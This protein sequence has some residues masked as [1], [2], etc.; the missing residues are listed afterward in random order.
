MDIQ[1][2]FLDTNV[3]EGAKFTYEDNKLSKLLELCEE[4]NI[5]VY[6]DST[7]YQEVQK[8]IRTNAEESCKGL[9]NKNLPFISRVSNLPE[10]KD[11]IQKQIEETL[12]TEFLGL[13][14]EGRLNIISK[15]ISH[16]EL[17]EMYFGEKAPFNVDNKKSEFPDA[18]IGLTLKEYINS[19]G[20]HILMISND[21]G[22]EDFCKSHK[23]E[24]VTMVSAALDILNK[25]FSVNTFYDKQQSK[26]ISEVEKYITS[27][28]IGFEIYSYGIEDYIYTSDY[29]ITSANVQNIYL[30]RGDDD[31]QSL[32]VTC[33]VEIEFDIT[34]E[35]YPD[36][37]FAIRDSE[38]DAWYTFGEK[39][40]RFLHKEVLELDFQ[41][42]ILDRANGIF[43]VTYVGKDIDI[44]FDAYFQG[45]KIISEEHFNDE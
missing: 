38:D 23:I 32:D 34:T 19:E 5:P 24:H 6:I 18:I 25:Q 17:L 35:R 12:T 11:I 28:E 7:V 16:E 21:N 30:V 13:I 36:Y 40:T 14:E 33:K 43:T 2:I 29:N 42:E 3:F 1:G 4:E 9:N 26:I 22:M 15:D 31:Y 44:I 41:V 20:E 10:K 37:E 39:Q 45:D 27:H 8:R